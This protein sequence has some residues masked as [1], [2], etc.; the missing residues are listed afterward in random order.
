MRATRLGKNRPLECRL[1]AENVL[2]IFLLKI[3]NYS[4][5]QERLISKVLA[6]IVYGLEPEIAWNYGISFLQ[7][8]KLFGP[9]SRS[10]LR[11]LSNRFSKSSSCRL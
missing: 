7:G 10:Y 6:E 8:F 4:Q 5:P 1:D 9:K 2:R 3:K 11:F